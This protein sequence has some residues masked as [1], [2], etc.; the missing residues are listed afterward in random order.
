MKEELKKAI[1]VTTK[2]LWLM[3]QQAGVKVPDNCGTIIIEARLKDVV[4]IYYQCFADMEAT[5]TAA[6]VIMKVDSEL[7][8]PQLTIDERARAK[9]RV[10]WETSTGATTEE[11]KA[12]WADAWEALPREH[13]GGWYRAVTA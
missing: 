8:D 5:Q 12:G 9:F 10:Y 13:K 4:R 7:S 3:L 11:E 2:D 1:C 6:G